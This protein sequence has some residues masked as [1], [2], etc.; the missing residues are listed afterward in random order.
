MPIAKPLQAAV[1]GATCDGRILERVHISQMAKNVNKQVRGARVNLEH[2]RGYSPTSDFRA[3]GDVEEVSEFEIQ[4]GPL[5][6]KLA[7]QSKIDATD[8][9][10]ALNTN[11]QKIDSSIEI[12][13]SFA[14]TGEA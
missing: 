9:M 7:L 12:H 11:R 6:G 10:V 2:I 1:E 5:K 13:P 8:D 14:D 3:Y 4:D